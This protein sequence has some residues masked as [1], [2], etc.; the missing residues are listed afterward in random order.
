MVGRNRISNLIS[1]TIRAETKPVS[2]PSLKQEQVLKAERKKSPSNTS[3][4]LGDVS[5]TKTTKADAA[6][7]SSHRRQ[8]AEKLLPG[9]CNQMIVTSLSTP[10]LGSQTAPSERLAV[11][12][13][14]PGLPTHGFCLCHGQSI[15]QQS[16]F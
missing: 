14:P 11:P 10:K 8:G 7:L 4:T 1:L 12:C 2:V 9:L 16:H 6:C 5:P 13:K 3:S 15:L